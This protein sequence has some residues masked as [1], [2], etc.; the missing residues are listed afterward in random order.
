MKHSVGNEPST[1]KPRRFIP[2]VAPS[3]PP[4]TKEATPPERPQPSKPV[5]SESPS[6]TGKALETSPFRWKMGTTPKRKRSDTPP[7]SPQVTPKRRSMR[8]LHARSTG[9]S[10]SNVEAAETPT[11]VT[12]DDDSD[13]GDTTEFEAD[14]LEQEN[15]DDIGDMREDFD[16]DYNDDCNEDA[17]AYS[18]DY[19]GGQCGL[20]AFLGS[21]GSSTRHFSA[22]LGSNL[23]A[24]IADPAWS[25]PEAEHA[26]SNLEI[27]PVVPSPFNT[28]NTLVEAALAGSSPTMT[29]TNSQDETP[30][31][32]VTSP[33]PPIFRHFLQRDLDPTISPTL[34][35]ALRSN[36]FAVHET[37]PV[38]SHIQPHLR[39]SG[40][41][42]L[43]LLPAV[44]PDNASAAENAQ[45]IITVAGNA[46]AKHPPNISWL[47]REESFTAFMAFF[48]SGAQV[49]RSADELLPLCHR[50]NGYAPFWGILFYPETIAALEKFLDKYGDFMD[51]TSITSSFSRCAAFRTLGL[52]QLLDITDHRLLC[53][54][55]AVCEAMTLGF[56]AESLLNL[57]KD[58][59]RAVFGARVV[60]NMKSNPGPNEIRVAAEALVFKQHELEKQ[61][62][63]LRGLL[64]AQGVSPDSA[65]CMTEAVT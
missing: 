40:P 51:M 27:V 7:V 18:S 26:A 23:A 39:A 29:P 3:G 62:R 50:F 44:Q 36:T 46:A 65:D 63:E 15:V 43:A 17:F 53:W 31:F 10:T 22:E 9:T 13:D 24:A 6:R 5:V 61:H 59:A 33:L 35:A 57:V 20:D 38:P 2:K 32:Q 42:P 21:A 60:H 52:V 56:R 30:T 48:D 58:L 19:P 37:L 28:F 14:V 34:P 25:P 12:V 54:R 47:E 45:A 41:S 4:R 11:V 55:D 8:I 49:L 1:G 64:S 16:R